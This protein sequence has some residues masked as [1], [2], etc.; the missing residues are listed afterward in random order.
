MK[1]KKYIDILKCILAFSIVVLHVNSNSLHRVQNFLTPLHKDLSFAT[2]QL[3]YIAVAVFIMLTGCGL[4]SAAATDYKHM[5]PRIR[6]IFLCIVIFGCFFEAV[7]I[8]LLHE[9]ISPREFVIDL[10]SGTSMSH[11]WYLNSLLG[12]YLITPLIGN[13]I[14]SKPVKETVMLTAICLFFSCL[15]P[16]VAGLAGLTYNEFFPVT[17]MFV[18]LSLTGY[19]IET[20]DDDV[21]RRYLPLCIAGALL[22]MGVIFWI[23][24]K[25]GT[26]V[27]QNHPLSVIAAFFIVFGAKG[28]FSRSAGSRKLWEN[29]SRCT[30]GI[31]IIHPL[32]IHMLFSFTDFNPQLHAPLLTVPLV[33]VGVFILS[34]A[35]TYAY[36]SVKGR[37]FPRKS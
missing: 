3:L 4:F 20:C 24:F 9:T 6:K 26:I 11:M 37:I 15:F 34:C 36:L 7:R 10:L 32:F 33:S 27:L 5:W 13:F 19:L 25:K 28:L 17:G 21:C 18:S 35:V 14:Q 30:L 8:L 22:S 2:H 31:Y 1:R 16:F 29:I 12:L 23:A